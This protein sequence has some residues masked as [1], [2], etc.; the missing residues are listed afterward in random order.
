MEDRDGIVNG[1]ELIDERRGSSDAGK[2]VRATSGGYAFHI[3][4][5]F[6]A[7]AVQV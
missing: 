3:P 5:M 1:V 7:C 2:N 6:G 4:V